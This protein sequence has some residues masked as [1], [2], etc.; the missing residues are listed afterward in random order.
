MK[1]N[2]EI[3]IIPLA[4]LY[5]FLPIIFF[6]FGWMKI[7]YAILLTVALI[8]FGYSFFSHTKDNSIQLFSNNTLLYWIITALVV[9]AWVYFSG[10]GGYAYQNDDFWVR[11]PIYR[12]LTVCK[13]PVIYDLAQ[14]PE[15]VQ[16]ICGSGKVA[17][18]YYFSWWLVPA[19]ISKICGMG[20]WGSKLILFAWAYCGIMLVVYLLNRMLKKCSWTVPFVLIGFGGLDAVMYSIIERRIPYMTHVEWWAENLFQYSSNTT[21]LYWV[22]NQAIPI[23][24]IMAVFVQR[25]D[26]RFDAAILSCIFAYSPWAMIGAIPFIIAG[27]V[28]NR[29]TL[30]KAINISNIAIPVIMLLVFG[31]FYMSSNGAT[32]KICSIFSYVGGRYGHVALLWMLFVF[33]EEGIFF[34]I[35][36]KQKS[37]F[38]WL[39]L[40]ELGIIPLI[41]LIDGN[42]VMRSSIPVLFVLTTFIISF[43]AEKGI[44]S[45]SIRKVILLIALCIGMWTPLNEINRSVINTFTSENYLMEPIYSFTSID[46]EKEHLISTISNQFFVYGYEDELFFKYLGRK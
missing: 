17:F 43:L 9:F 20:D 3:V 6:C 7:P 41:R 12:D 36:G 18:S 34:L 2:W 23:W 14:E 13:W 15:Y 25:R 35:M 11:N 40:V 4:L 5:I 33:V 16:S 21:Q 27:S 42:F 19:F 30:K 1:K 24:V 26:N 28:K 39:V 38:Y 31:L 46:S 8:Y 37:E 10:I 29:D 32:G 44:E 22:F 45:R